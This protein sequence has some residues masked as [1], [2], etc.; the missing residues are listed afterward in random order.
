MASPKTIASRTYPTAATFTP[1]TQWKP[2]TYDF[3]VSPR[4]AAFSMRDPASYRGARR[5][6]A[7]VLAAARRSKARI[8]ALAQ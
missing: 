7:R 5:N 8:T 3:V 6:H 2:F 1:E 4:N